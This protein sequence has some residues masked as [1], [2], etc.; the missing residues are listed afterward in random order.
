MK[1][2][3]I[4]TLLVLAILY[5]LPNCASIKPP[6]GGPRDTIPPV[7]LQST[8][9][10]KSINYKG[11]TIQLEFDEYLKIDNL[12]K[13]LII[14]PIIAEEYE[15]QVK[16]YSVELKFEKAFKDSTTFT[17]NFQDA[18]QD[19]TESNV[20]KSN[21][22]AFS[23]TD[24]ID[25]M[26]VFG[27]VKDIFTDK[28]VEAFTV[29]LYELNDT[30]DIFNS[31]PMYLARTNEKGLYSIEN[32]K[33]G[34]YRIYVYDD[35]NSNLQCDV[36]REKYGFIRDT[37]DLFGEIDSVHLKVLYNDIREMAITRA[38]PAGLY[39][40]IKMNKNLLGYEVQALDPG[41]ELYNNY[42][43]D[44]KTIRLYNNLPPEDS[45][46]FSLTA[47]DS[48]GNTLIDTMFLKFTESKRKPEN[49]EYSI[50]PKNKAKIEDR[51]HTTI[52]FTK[53]VINTVI[54][55]IYFIYDSLTVQNLPDSIQFKM[56]DK[57]DEI[58][59]EVDLFMKEYMNKIKELDT[60]K[61]E[62]DQSAE[63]GA[64][65]GISR[66]KF[67][68]IYH[69]GKG[70][71]ISVENDS[72]PQIEYTYTLINPADYGIIRGKAMT[73]FESYFI[74]LLTK[75][76]EVLSEVESM[77]D[78]EMKQIDPG[79]YMIRILVDENNN[80]RWDPGNILQ[81]DEPEKII[82]YPDPISIR[83]NWEITDINLEF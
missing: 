10:H 45:V 29:C 61:T 28:A 24:Y 68:L 58:S 82:F 74:Q 69:V 30:L 52:Q 62:T 7:L 20:T 15:I 78:W 66:K 21:V 18:I 31:P 35:Q 33:T 67:E 65:S 9:A 38:G 77:S 40:E 53:P 73:S 76:G 80:G 11:N 19:I 41:I 50:L 49:F 55:S 12:Q 48:V 54:D 2:F 25:S 22:L 39:Y 43:G 83:A 37:L 5:F 72:I 51:I 79:D 3:L 6:G 23:T 60:V 36:P 4:F 46:A 44:F 42:G 34:S 63:K 26:M 8:P 13:Q 1:D 17:F 71:F 14:T 16:K 47:W 56:N 32:I 57:K 75:K 81:N 64:R 59:F 70:S 27:T